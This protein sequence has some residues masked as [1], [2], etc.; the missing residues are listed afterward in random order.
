[1]RGAPGGPAAGADLPHAASAP[2]AAMAPST[3]AARARMPG[4][5]ARSRRR[6]DSLAS[7][8]DLTLELAPQV[9]AEPGVAELARGE[10]E[11]ELGLASTQVVARPG[12]DLVL[13]GRGIVAEPGD[14]RVARDH[15]EP[16]IGDV[17]DL[18]VRAEQREV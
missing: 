14:D 18:G 8:P 7:E 9:V 12:R 4:H 11:L 3:T 16:R 10:V 6:R 2:R 13:V 15:A 5:N 17:A 1:S